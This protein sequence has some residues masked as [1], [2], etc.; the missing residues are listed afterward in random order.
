[1]KGD[2]PILLRRDDQTC[3]ARARLNFSCKPL[4]D[5]IK[6]INPGLVIAAD[7][8]ESVIIRYD[9]FGR[10]YT[11]YDLFYVPGRKV[12]DDFMKSAPLKM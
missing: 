4:P 6:H 11:P 8:S 2:D 10:R 7:Q 3:R 5:D 1:M 9:V 12:Y